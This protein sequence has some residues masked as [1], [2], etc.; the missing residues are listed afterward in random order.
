MSA[1]TDHPYCS[2]RLSGEGQIRLLKV[3]P[4][5]GGS[6]EIK[7]TLDTV[8][9]DDSPSY[10]AL[11]Y[12]WGPPTAE[13]ADAEAA[14]QSTY[15]ITCNQ[16]VIQITRNLNDFLQMV[17]REP[18]LHSRR[19]WVDAVC[20]NQ[21]DATE[22]SSQVGFMASIYRSADFVIAWLGK[23]DINTEESFTL[24][25]TLAT[26]CEDCLAQIMPKNRAYEPFE[27]V[28][29]QMAND[30]AWNALRQ[31][32]R[33]SYFKRAWTIQ[34]VALAKKVMVK[35]GGHLLDW[36]HIV[37]VSLFLTVTPW[38]R[39]LNLGVRD[40]TDRE[41]SNH[42]QPLYLDANGKS[43]VPGSSHSLLYA[44]I[45]AR[46][47]ECS[48]PRDKVY[49][50]L[51]LG[52]GHVN[53]KPRLQPLYGGRSVV[54][55]YISTAIQIL[56]DTNDLLLLAHAE[57]K[58]FQSFEGLPSWT[59]DW[60]CS[61]GL[62]LGI[63]GYGRFA[64][65]RNL[66]RSLKIDEPNKSLVLRGMLLDRIV[67]IGESKA[68]ALT[69]RKHA[70]FPGWV[71][72]LSSLPMVY[73]TGQPRN[74]VFWRTLITDTAARIP[75]PARHPAAGEYKNAFRDWLARIILLWM[76]EPPSTETRYFLDALQRLAASDGVGLPVSAT[77]KL[78]L[79]LASGSLPGYSVDLPG[80]RNSPD[81]D[82]YDAILNHSA[83]TR[84]LRTSANYLGIAT[85]SIKVGDL[86]WIVSGSRVP[87][88]FRKASPRNEYYLVGGAYIHGFMQ[89]EALAP[90]PELLDIKVV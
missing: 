60:S 17:R 4:E 84:L 21:Q 80:S 28:L 79:A 89:G 59:P 24:I 81:A 82:D 56:E 61:K 45:R 42:A 31:F 5:A 25:R 47:F 27:N 69:L 52:E 6:R 54:D 63:V 76:D 37:K 68:E 58:D 51:G 40:P 41:Y 70:Y 16:G 83:Q 72:I 30:R 50:L 14:S 36:D 1:F 43:A 15:T 67:Q 64:A 26:L 57:G 74:E 88:I 66:P 35:C 9:L 22:R 78:D 87:L 12:T 39:F 77:G 48:D 34:E 8:H 73:H 11:S 71:S 49:A 7:C 29:G 10:V 90:Y 32:W 2:S 65:A 75:H 38:T 44:L 13:M 53:E 85:T 3:Q 20:I 46:R 19:F 23:E 86:I 55:A 33:R 62:G 18:E